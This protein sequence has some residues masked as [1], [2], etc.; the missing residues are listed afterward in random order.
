MKQKIKTLKNGLENLNPRSKWGK[1]VKEDAIDLIDWLEYDNVDLSRIE[2]EGLEKVLLNGGRDWKESSYGGSALIYDS[3]IASHYCT[4]S[5][6]KKCKGGLNPPNSRE[7]WLDVQARALYQAMRLIK[8]VNN[9]L[10]L[11]IKM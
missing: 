10:Q 7:N 9:S 6:L 8:N 1:A 4:L 3:Q 2:K 5:E 11:G